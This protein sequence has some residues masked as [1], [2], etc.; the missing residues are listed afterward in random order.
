[1]TY[2]YRNITEE[3]LTMLVSVDTVKN[4][5]VSMLKSNAVPRLHEITLICMDEKSLHTGQVA[6]YPGFCSMKRLGVFLLPLDGMSI[7]GHSSWMGC[8]SIAGLPPALISPVPVYTPG[9]REA[10]CD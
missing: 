1:M 4:N 2:K 3:V 8:Q 10:L 9:C 6:A 7:P 5:T